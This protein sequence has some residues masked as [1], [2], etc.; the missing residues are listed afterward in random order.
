[1]DL[2]AGQ[3]DIFQDGTLIFDDAFFAFSPDIQMIRFSLSS[4]NLMSRVV[5][6]NVLI[7][8]RV[9]EP[10][11]LGLLALACGA[12]L[13]ARMLRTHGSWGCREMP[14]ARRVS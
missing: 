12:L 9:P 14:A 1:V 3:I 8:A 4:D 10:A 2:S 5:V 11:A 6:D 13:L 7:T